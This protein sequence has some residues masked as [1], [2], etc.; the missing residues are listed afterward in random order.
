MPDILP[1]YSIHKKKVDLN[2]PCFSTGI[3]TT[4]ID[5]SSVTVGKR[6]LHYFSRL[7][8]L[9]WRRSRK[10]SPFAIL[11]ASAEPLLSTTATV[12]M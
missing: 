8:L 3:Y 12:G 9:T 4:E 2:T 7:V 1:I 5:K 6:L 10:K 11:L